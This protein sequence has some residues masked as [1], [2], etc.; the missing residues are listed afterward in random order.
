MKR[1]K[2]DWSF[3][4]MLCILGWLN[5]T[6]CLLI[7]LGI[8]IHEAGHF[9]MLRLLGVH[10]HW[11][12]LSFGGAMMKTETMRYRTELLC[13]LAGP[14][15]GVLAAA[16][17]VRW[18]PWFSIVNACLALANLLPIYPLDGGRVLAVCL[19]GCES[20]ETIIHRVNIITCCSLMLL[21][22][23]LTVAMQT[24]I[25]PM[26]LALLALWRAGSNEKLLLFRT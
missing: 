18:F 19:A 17:C 16:I 23:W 26:F 9:L 11:L 13:A 22:V 2:I 24:G 8:L 15:A 6:L 1:V 12:R 21:A 14:A 25:W 20:A 10:V 3:W 5:L 4:V 7:L